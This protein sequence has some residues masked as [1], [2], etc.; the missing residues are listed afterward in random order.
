MVF[1]LNRIPFVIKEGGAQIGLR[2]K[3]GKSVL[4]A[5]D[6]KKNASSVFQ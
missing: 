3:L 6:R 4:I 1:A 5:I 2:K